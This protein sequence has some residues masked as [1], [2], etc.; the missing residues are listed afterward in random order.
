MNKARSRLIAGCLGA[1][2]AV[3]GCATKP[4]AVADKP[5]MRAL[6]G[7]VTTPTTGASDESLG[8]EIRRQLT[9]VDAAGTAGVIV[10]VSAGVVT[11]RGAAPSLTTAWRAAAVAHAVA[12]VK[13][14]RNAVLIQPAAGR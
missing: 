8:M 9:V 13:E 3:A 6:G 1:L 11:L 4:P 10:D 7:A 2:V 14:V 12:G 5:A